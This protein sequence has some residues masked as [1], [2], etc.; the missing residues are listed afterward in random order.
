MPAARGAHPSIRDQHYVVTL[1]TEV[2]KSG[3]WWSLRS[4]SVS[5]KFILFI[6]PLFLLLLPSFLLLS[7]LHSSSFFIFQL[8]SSF[9][10]SSFKMNGSWSFDSDRGAPDT[11]TTPD[12][13]SSPQLLPVR[14]LLSGSPPKTMSFSAFLDS[15]EESAGSSLTK[16]QSAALT[17]FIKRIKG[18]QLAQSL[19]ATLCNFTNAIFNILIQLTG[20]ESFL[21]EFFF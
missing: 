11:P 1:I 15:K 10:L 16:E 8:L 5:W 6:T 19:Y 18:T 2:E 12:D 9:F 17:E 4:S 13:S 7:L 3:A 20:L 21:F 14:T